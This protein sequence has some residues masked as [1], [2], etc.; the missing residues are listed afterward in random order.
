MQVAAAEIH[1]KERAQYLVVQAV[2]DW[3]AEE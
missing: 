1:P 2:V 3:V